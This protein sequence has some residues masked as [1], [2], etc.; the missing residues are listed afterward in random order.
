MADEMSR[1]RRVM[2]AREGPGPGPG[3]RRGAGVSFG[4]GMQAGRAGPVMRGNQQRQAMRERGRHRLQICY[5]SAEPALSRPFY[6][7]GDARESGDTSEAVTAFEAAA[8]RL[9]APTVAHETGW[10]DRQGRLSLTE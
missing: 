3:R 2:C 4:S 1:T 5:H 10:P 6:A 7:T 8:A 9:E